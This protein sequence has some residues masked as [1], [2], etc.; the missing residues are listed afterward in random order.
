MSSRIYEHFEVVIAGAGSSGISAAAQ[1][2]KQGARVCILEKEASVGGGFV[3]AGLTSFV[4]ALDYEILPGMYSICVDRNQYFSVDP[5]KLQQFYYDLLYQ[6]NILLISSAWVMG[7]EQENGMINHLSVLTR[8][9]SMQIDGEVFIDATGDGDLSFLCSV[10]FTEG[11]EEDGSSMPPIFCFTLKNCKDGWKDLRVEKEKLS[12]FGISDIRLS[13]GLLENEVTVMLLDKRKA[14]ASSAIDRARVDM[15][16]RASVIPVFSYLREHDAF[17]ESTMASWGDH[18]VFPEGRHPQGRMILDTENLVKGTHFEDWVVSNI[19]SPM[20]LTGMEDIEETA[21]VSCYDIPYR[22]LIPLRVK[23][24]L[25]SGRCISGTHR[26]H[27]SF[28]S[29]E[30]TMATGQAAGAAA[31]QA[32]EKNKKVQKVDIKRLQKTM[33]DNGMKLPYWAM[34]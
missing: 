8:E 6:Q 7:A 23:N 16:L 3:H 29:L 2:A 17:S 20:N 19:S 5:R 33:M 1:A 26:A 11:R 10:P 15:D 12:A 22:A 4:R 28:R 13:C 25:L 9:G 21:M 24:L 18:I 34:I 31:V 14:K 32:L 27:G 30:T